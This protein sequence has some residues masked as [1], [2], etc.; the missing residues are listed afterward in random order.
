MGEVDEKT[1]TSPP[2]ATVNEVNT[3]ED[4]QDDSPHNPEC[5]HPERMDGAFFSII[6]GAALPCLTILSVV[7]AVLGIIFV[8]LV[9]LDRGWP[10]LRS[11]TALSVA[12]TGVWATL[13]DWKKR[14]GNAAFYIDFN[15]SSL[16][17]VASLSSKI[18]PY[19]SSTIM[20]LVSFF[21]ARQIIKM[22]QDQKDGDLLSPHQLSI[23]IELLGGKSFAPIKDCV[24][25][26]VKKKQRWISPITHAF[27]ALVIVTTLG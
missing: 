5:C 23:L 16:T 6:F 24:H 20:A 13:N 1:K 2:Q 15:P 17:A 22:S 26:H 4:S 9:D 7:G 12:T 3:P 11:R 10:E 19:L 27:A 14:G 21:A 18:I 8:N 25:F